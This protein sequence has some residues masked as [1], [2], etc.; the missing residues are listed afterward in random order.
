V[1]GGAQREGGFGRPRRRGAAEGSERRGPL[2]GGIQFQGGD[3]VAIKAIGGRDARAAASASAASSRVGEIA[4]RVS[5][6][7]VACDEA[8]RIERAIRS[9]AGL[10]AEVLV[11]DSGSSDGTA[12]LSERL[13]ARVV[14]HPWEGFGPQKRFA[15]E[16]AGCDW[17]LSL[18]ADEWLS[19]GLRAELAALLA[20]PLPPARCYR[21]RVRIVYPRRET[22][23]PFAYFHNYVRL[24]NRTTARCRDS[25]S[26]DEV[27]PTADVAQLDGD[28]LHKSYRDFAHIVA[29]TVAYYQT[30]RAEG[31][32]PSRMALLRQF[33]EFPF[34][35]FK[36]YVLRRHIFGGADGFAYAT[37]LAM[38]RWA[39]IFILRGW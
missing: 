34:Q 9:V 27:E 26:H 5:C 28:I 32:R 11:V 29:K 18:D 33:G 10:V 38:G 17:I 7:I 6:V 35:F 22:P 24:Y 20:K 31:I 15:E 1:S 2:L 19:D 21:A 39:R 16:Q 25:L 8:D 36:Y 13:G 23:A 37:A 30:Q 3:G 4:N 12:A 14:L